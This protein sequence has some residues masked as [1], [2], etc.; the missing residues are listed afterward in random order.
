M[1]RRKQIEF[2]DET[3]FKLKELAADRMATFQ[4]LAD[5]AFA[6]LLKKYRRPIG[7]RSALRQSIADDGNVVELPS[8]RRARRKKPGKRRGQKRKVAQRRRRRR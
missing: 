4:D 7:L 8:A 2:D 5:E 1:P 3:F 6:D